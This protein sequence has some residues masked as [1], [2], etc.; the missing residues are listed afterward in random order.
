MHFISFLKNQSFFLLTKEMTLFFKFLKI[1][2]IF[3]NILQL[4]CGTVHV[5]KELICVEELIIMIC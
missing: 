1:D 4:F 3:C 5:Y 2:L